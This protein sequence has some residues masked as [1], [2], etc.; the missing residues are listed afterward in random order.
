MTSRAASTAL[1]AFSLMMAA[2]GAL[3]ATLTGCGRSVVEGAILKLR[4]RKRFASVNKAR[5]L[6]TV[7]AKTIESLAVAGS[8]DIRYYGDPTVE[9]SVVGSGSVCRLGAAPS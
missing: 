7:N 4:F 6:V 2:A 8:G 5:I 9:R 1:L 3:A